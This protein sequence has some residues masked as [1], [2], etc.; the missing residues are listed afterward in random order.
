MADGS[1]RIVRFKS[2]EIVEHWLLLITFAIL[3]FTGLL[4]LFARVPS[5]LDDQYN[6][7]RHR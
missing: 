7:W 6:L 2:V 1:R 4:Q 5:R 3:G